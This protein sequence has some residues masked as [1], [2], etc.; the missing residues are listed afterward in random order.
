MSSSETRLSESPPRLDPSTLALLDSFLASKADEE[1]RFNE[2]Q[3]T[4]DQ[5]ESEVSTSTTTALNVDEFRL[6]FGEDWQLS[7]FWYTTTFA[8]H[9][10]KSLLTL[11][12]SSSTKVGFVCCPTGYVAFQNYYAQTEGEGTRHPNTKLLEIDHRFGVLAKEQYVYYDLFKPDEYPKDLNGWFDLIIVDPPFLNEETNTS[13]CTTFSQILN[14]STGKLLII[15]GASVQET[16]LKVY[17]DSPPTGPLRETKL[18]VKHTGLANEFV[19]LG[20]W[21]GAEE[22]GG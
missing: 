11:I 21:S 5:D 12:P 4:E 20:S 9:L 16:C 14:P 2:L 7:Q 19:C 1:R 15:T 3:T 6:A 10:A 13:L 18:D 17:G 22:W 8:T